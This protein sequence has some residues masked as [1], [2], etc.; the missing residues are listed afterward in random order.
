MFPMFTAR[1]G[2][3]IFTHNDGTP[4]PIQSVFAS[5]NADGTTLMFSC[6]GELNARV[7]EV[8]SQR[9][10]LKVTLTTVSVT[11][12]LA[13]RNEIIHVLRLLYENRLIAESFA[14]NITRAYPDQLGNVMPWIFRIPETSESRDESGEVLTK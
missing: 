6:S 4:S 1:A 9:Q 14:Q 11:F 12:S 2:D 10:S 8:V 3:K 13:E 7:A 5:T